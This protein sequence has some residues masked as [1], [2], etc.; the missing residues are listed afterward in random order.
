MSNYVYHFP[1]YRPVCNTLQLYFYPYV[2]VS[3]SFPL[4]HYSW[5]LYLDSIEISRVLTYEGCRL[6][7]IPRDAGRGTEVTADLGQ[8]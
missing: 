1:I 7:Q 5:D 4:S 2:Q 8:M 3:K 6:A